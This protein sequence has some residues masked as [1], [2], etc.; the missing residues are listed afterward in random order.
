MYY[1]TGGIGIGKKTKF[2]F[3]EKDYAV[4]HIAINENIKK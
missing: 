2:I 3:I 4:V 1:E